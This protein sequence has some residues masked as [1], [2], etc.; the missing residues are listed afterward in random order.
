M[1]PKLEWIDFLDLYSQVNNYPSMSPSSS[2]RTT[3]GFENYLF[4]PEKIREACSRKPRRTRP[5]PRGRD[6]YSAPSIASSSSSPSPSPRGRDR[7]YPNSSSSSS[8]SRSGSIHSYVSSS[9][10]SDQSYS[11]SSSSSSSSSRSGSR[12]YGYIPPPEP[13]RY[14]NYMYL[15]LRDSLRVM[16]DVQK[17]LEDACFSYGDQHL[18]E[19][20]EEN[21]WDCPEA[22]ELN[23]WVSILS[24]R[25]NFK[26]LSHFSQSTGNTKDLR[27]L[28]ESMREIR[29]TTVHRHRH[30]VTTIRILVQDAIAFCRILREDT[31]LKELYAIWGA[32]S[33][34]IDQLYEKSQPCPPPEPSILQIPS[35][36]KLLPESQRETSTEEDDRSTEAGSEYTESSTTTYSKEHLFWQRRTWQ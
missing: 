23:T 34:Q 21:G 17:T 2:P 14:G 11:P 22:V 35:S 33:L 20:L 9:Y 7:S 12:P 26:L 3:A 15:P 5:S 10:G 27:D 16:S 1:S 28:L 32:A 29:H 25:A 18:P 31:C 6:T 19:V 36:P 24:K 8:S 4:S 13:D 30:T